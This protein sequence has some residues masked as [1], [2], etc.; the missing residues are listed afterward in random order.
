MPQFAQKYTNT[1]IIMVN[2]PLRH[3]LALD[4]QINLEIRN[5]NNKLSK[6]AK[7]FSLGDLV[8]MNFDRKY[9]TKHGLHLNNVG[10]EGLAKVI[11]SQINKIIKC[12]LNDKPIIFL[13]WKDE[14]INKSIIVIVHFNSTLRTH[15]HVVVPR[16]DDLP[17]IGFPQ[18]S[19]SLLL[20]YTN[21]GLLFLKEVV[22]DIL[23]KRAYR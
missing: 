22:P 14:S 20:L 19:A 9:F 5:F 13:Q 2:I 12:S 18:S 4:S 17:F 7:L 3:D 1:N 16:S 8:E 23:S 10:E 6:R 15:L 11:T 21:L